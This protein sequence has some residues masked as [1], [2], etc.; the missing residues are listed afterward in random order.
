MKVASMNWL[1]DIMGLGDSKRSTSR[2]DSNTVGSL[3]E[4]VLKSRGTPLMLWAIALI[5]A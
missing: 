1:P 2:C 3:R 4:P 5:Q